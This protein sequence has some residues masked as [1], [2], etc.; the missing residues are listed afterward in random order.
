MSGAPQRMR[1][2]RRAFLVSAGAATVAIGAGSGYAL[3]RPPKVQAGLVLNAYLALLDDGGVQFVCPAQ[4]LGQGAPFALAMVLAEEMG[5]DPARVHIVAAPRD[6]ARYGNPA[7]GDRMVTAD[8]KTTHGYWPVLR[9]A[10]A[11]ARLAMVQTVCK[12]R[13]WRPEDCVA[14]AHAVHH[15]PSGSAVGF[16]E[17]ARAGRLSLPR[18]TAADLKASRAFTVLGRDPVNPELLDIVTGRKR[19]GVDVRAGDTQVAVLAR[20][21]H[22]GGTVLQVDDAQARA[23]PGV[24]QIVVLPDAVAVVA[25]HTWAALKGRAA[26]AIRWSPPGEFSSAGEAAKLAETLD[27]AGRQRVLLREKGSATAEGTSY[28]ASFH[29]PTLK[30]VLPEPLNATARPTSM[31]LGVEISGS[32]QSQDLDMRFAS[33]TWKTAPL[34]VTTQALPSGGAYGRRV[35]ND[36]VR[37][38]CLVAKPLQRPV[39]VIRPL[40]DELRRGQVRPAALQRIAA[41]L[42]D[43]GR[44]LSWRHELASDGTLASQLPSSLKGAKGDED[45]TATDGAYHPYRVPN[46][47]LSWTWVPSA[48]E[49]GF[50]RGVAAAYTVWAIETTVERLARAAGH[51]P[52]QWRLQHLDD[53]RLAKALNAV[54][55]MAGW[56]EGG[57]A[58]GLAL[59][60]F[61]DTAMA[62]VAEVKAGRVVGL[63]LAADVGQVVHRG[64]VLGQIEGGAIWGLSMALWEQ[65]EYAEGAAQI[66]HLSQYP[67]PTLADLPPIRIQLLDP[68]PDAAPCGVGEVG[69]PTVIPAVCNAFER[70]TGQ[71]FDRLPLQ[72]KAAHA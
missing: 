72:L 52:L 51:D 1:L 24:Q 61:R 45:N 33:R 53:P 16:D 50:L 42:D 28:S 21:P 27:D 44:L 49:P 23:V 13:G 35:L 15:Q 66:E 2:S 31:G 63:W 19:F 20:S 29:V 46:E 69:V 7:F 60:S 10:G 25:A 48:P 34:M 40:L 67:L 18:A 47:H 54:A 32:S 30:H 64:Q 5:A 12:A 36:A 11:E 3:T 70:A 22:L 26:L 58:L 62:C 38:A 71:R 8:S 57:R 14:R 65:L 59:M 56:G 6:A 37:D 4:N 68:A 9:L 41:E 17:I 55:A 43:H 39:Q